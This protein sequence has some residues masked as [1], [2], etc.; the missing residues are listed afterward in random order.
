LR[1]IAI[2]SGSQP[3]L[4]ASRRRTASN[5]RLEHL[6]HRIGGGHVG[7]VEVAAHRL[8]HDAWARAHPAV[9]QVDDRAVEREGLLDLEPEVLVA[10]DVV[11]RTAVHLPD[12][13]GELRQ[14]VVPE[15]RDR[16]TRG[17]EGLEET[18][19]RG[20]TISLPDERGG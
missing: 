4:A 5:L 20:H 13:A 7:V 1:V 10:G 15:R 8:L 9:V 3:K 11:G 14:R 18:A 12:D 6:P 19:A 16:G 2:S 17:Q